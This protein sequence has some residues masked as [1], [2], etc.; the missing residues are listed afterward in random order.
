MAII[1]CLLFLL[2]QYAIISCTRAS[3][4]SN[5]KPSMEFL[6]TYIHTLWH[7]MK[8]MYEKKHIK[9]TTTF[10]FDKKLKC[11]VVCAN[12]RER[13]KR[14]GHSVQFVLYVFA[15]HAFVSK[16]AYGSE[17]HFTFFFQLL[18][19]RA[20]RFKERKLTSSMLVSV[21]VI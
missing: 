8:H 11:I 9:K 21:C 13:E 1:F 2:I 5:H 14:A 18:N 7:K 3:V 12:F 19:R 17:I 10:G 4:S 6:L 20:Y 16:P 15:S